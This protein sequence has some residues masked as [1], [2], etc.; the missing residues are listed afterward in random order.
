[1]ANETDALVIRARGNGEALGQLYDLYYER[2]YRYSRHR[3]FVREVA[4]D[5]TSAVFLKVAEAIRG[6]RGVTEAEFKAWIYRITTNQINA[7][8]RQ[9]ARRRQLF[10][11]AAQQR[12][13]A[14]NPSGDAHPAQ[15]PAVY[16]AI[17]RLK[18][19]Y[20]S[21]I[22]MRFFE[23]LKADE[24]A[25]ILGIRPGTVRVCLSRA[26]HAVRRQLADAG[27]PLQR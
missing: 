22:T 8:V 21:V 4:E 27:K 11:A 2:I 23:G 20:Q 12:I 16:E 1:M 5:V 18:P 13:A 9:T 19:R 10:A 6:F 14:S 25:R 3:L 7:Y 17:L 15:W 24:I 26:L